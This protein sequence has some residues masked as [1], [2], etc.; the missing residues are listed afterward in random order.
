MEKEKVCLYVSDIN[1]NNQYTTYNKSRK[2][3][4][5]SQTED[6]SPEASFPDYREEL[7]WRNILFSTVL[8]LVRRK[9]IKQVRDTFLQGFKQ[10]NKHTNTYIANQYGLGT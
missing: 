9:N 6:C 3:F 10:T 4:Y 1:K 7:L 5:L 8:Y 2:K